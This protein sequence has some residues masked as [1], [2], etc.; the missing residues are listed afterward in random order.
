MAVTIRKGTHADA[1]RELLC[2]Y[3][4]YQCTTIRD[5]ADAVTVWTFD[6]DA[7]PAFETMEYNTIADIKTGAE[8]IA[9]VMAA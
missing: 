1:A 6:D 3:L 9:A 5:T 7:G 8:A 2:Y 4:A